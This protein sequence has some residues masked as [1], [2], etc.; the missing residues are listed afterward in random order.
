MDTKT[1]IREL[2]SVE[3]KHKH[4]KVFT[5]QLNIATMAHDVRKRLEEL[6]PYEDTGL[7]PEQIRELKEALSRENTQE[8]ARLSRDNEVTECCPHCD[9]EITVSW[10]VEQDGYQIF[11]PNCGEPIMLCSMCDARDGKVCD[12]EEIKGCKHSDE[13]YRDYF[14]KNL[15]CENVEEIA[16]SSRDNDGWISVEERLPEELA[17]VLV[18]ACVPVRKPGWDKRKECCV[19]VD[20]DVYDPEI[21]HGWEHFKDKVTAWMPLPEPYQREEAI[22]EKE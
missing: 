15:S 13:R 8:T 4:D 14:Y 20:T 2:E 7:T 17:P 10:D 1:M 9:R 11:C 6:K 5:G 21:K 12:W 3:E 19:V 18:T 16:R 22:N